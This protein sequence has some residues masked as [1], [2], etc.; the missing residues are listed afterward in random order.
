LAGQFGG[1][2]PNTPAA[3]YWNLSI[4]YLFT[5]STETRIL[6]ITFLS[7]GEIDPNRNSP[8]ELATINKFLAPSISLVQQFMPAE[9]DFWTL[10]NWL[11]VGY[12]WTLLLDF[13]QIQPTIY[14]PQ[15]SSEV[16]ITPPDFSQPTF[17]P[18][19]NNIFLND[20]LFQIYAPITRTIASLVNVTL[21]EFLPV[22]ETNRLQTQT[23][24]FVRGYDCQKREIKKGWFFAVFAVEFAFMSGAYHL[25]IVI[26]HYIGHRR[27]NGSSQDFLLFG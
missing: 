18:A 19:T 22:G 24:T 21:P 5:D 1:G 27:T 8:T 11:F 12:Y 14:A 2:P 9:I 17:Y 16:L 10:M 23:T 4:I 7:T 26:V 6:N 3:D 15:T 13:G 20:T 25:F